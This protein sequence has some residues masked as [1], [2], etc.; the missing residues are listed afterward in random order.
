MHFDTRLPLSPS[1][2]SGS[3]SLAASAEGCRLRAR[4]QFSKNKAAESAAWSHCSI[5]Y[6]C[7][8]ALFSATVRHYCFTAVAGREPGGN[9]RRIW[10]SKLS[11]LFS[12]H[13]INLLRER[14]RKLAE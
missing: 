5:I 3:A 9:Q 4:V 6:G 14:Q 10:L 1:V 2:R 13:R 12:S 11:I 7:I 8:Q